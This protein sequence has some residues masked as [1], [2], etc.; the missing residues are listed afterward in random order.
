M[1]TASANMPFDAICTIVN[2]SSRPCTISQT[3]QSDDNPTC[4]VLFVNI[5]SARNLNPNSSLSYAMRIT[6]KRKGTFSMDIPFTIVGD[7]IVDEVC[8][9]IGIAQ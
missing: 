9:V 7:S 8:S 2:N 1:F 6:P 5:F 4:N 3:K